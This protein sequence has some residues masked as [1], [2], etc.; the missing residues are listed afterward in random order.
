MRKCDDGGLENGDGCNSNC[1]VENGFEWSGGSFVHADACIEICGDGLD[2][3]KHECDDGDKDDGDGWSST[4]EIEQW[5][6]CKGGT[7]SSPD[8]C[9][10]L[11]ITSEL[12]KT[13]VPNE[14]DVA[15]SIDMIQ[16]AISLKDLL[17]NVYSKF[18]IVVTWTARYVDS[19]TLRI[20]LITNSVLIGDEIVSLKFI[21]YKVFRGQYGGW[22]VSTEIKT[23]SAGNLIK[24]E[25]A[26]SSF[27]IFAQYGTYFGILVTLMLVLIGGG[28]FEILW[29]LI[30][31]MQIIS[32]LP[33]MT[34]F[35]PK[36][37]QIMFEVLK[38][39][40]MNF[41]FLSDI[42]KSMVPLNFSQIK[43]YNEVF[44]K[45]GIENPLFLE[46]CASILWSLISYFGIFLISIILY[47]VSWWTKMKNLFSNIASSFIF[48]NFLR[49]ITEGYLELIFGSFLNV[50]SFRLSSSPEKISF[51]FSAIFM[52]FLTLFPFFTFALIYD[53]RKNLIDN[54]TYVKRYGTMF[55]HLKHDGAWYKQQFYPAFLVRRLVFAISLIALEGIPEIQWNIFI[56]SA[57]LVSICLTMNL[58]SC[59]FNDK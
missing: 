54:E 34:P 49:F 24:S 5:F 13:S 38:F 20:T 36:H 59:I 51:A 25:E 56:L 44:T 15:F 23:S 12:K 31:S 17:V 50:Y 48:N 32:Y 6:E 18:S 52:L 3:E 53:N 37:V 11:N 27:S 46:N 9:I 43:S 42:F 14:Y 2:F 57:L 35:F 40:N 55:K 19:K 47:K 22:L 29:A 58:D 8:K 21:N 41:S 39:S 10:P 16:K 4:C 7:K 1:E 26:A 28:S 33:L 45:N 30:N